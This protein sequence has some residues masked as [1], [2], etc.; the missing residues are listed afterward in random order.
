[1]RSLLALLFLFLSGTAASDNFDDAVAAYADG[2]YE[3]AYQL[4]R[5]LADEEDA[6]AMFD[7][8]VL[9]WEGQG[10]PRSHSLAVK[11]WQRAAERNIAAAQYNLGLAHY[12]GK[13]V[14]QDAQQ[15]L[16]LIGL[17]AEQG[18]DIAKRVLPILEEEL[19]TYAKSENIQYAYVG[20]PVGETIAKLYASRNT[21]TPPLK[22]LE[23][24]TPIKVLSTNGVWSQ[25][26]IPGGITLWVFGKYV[27]ATDGV[28][29]ISGVGVRIRTAP[30]TDKTSSVVGVLNN[31]DTVQIVAELGNWK[32][33]RAPSSIVAWIPNSHVRIIEETTIEWD[34]EWKLA[35]DRR[36]NLAVSD[37]AKVIQAPRSLDQAEPTLTSPI[38]APN[39]TP[40]DQSF[41][42]AT[43]SANA[44]E[45][46]GTIQ[47]GAQLLKL[48]ARDTPIRII[49]QRD[50]WARVEVPTGLYVWVYGKYVHENQGGS[51][52]NTDHVRA[53]SL[54]STNR[55]STVVGILAKD[56]DV[57]FISRQGDW[58]RVKAFDSVSGW[59][60]MEQLILLD[61]V[62]EAWQTSWSEFR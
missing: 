59:V 61:T 38:E 1:M 26:D 35:S 60:L 30:V 41:R 14:S 34:L 2:N 43:V 12:L 24:G 22:S 42:A 47:P 52:I 49:E 55:E 20:A 27:I 39:V 46:M 15:A 33:I 31:G 51:F 29:K 32:Q 58:K 9:Y 4:W 36:S 25:V 28:E 21:E 54:P 56:T 8:G 44:A 17:A 18:H 10:V 5:S 48:L 57:S 50:K 19:A 45:V 3:K 16:N 37:P 11:W 13:E 7:L 62:T 40:A 53:R 6:G 23:V